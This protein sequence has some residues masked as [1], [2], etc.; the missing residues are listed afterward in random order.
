MRVD[1]ETAADFL[2]RTPESLRCLLSGVRDDWMRAHYGEGTWSPFD[3]VGHLIHG[4]RTDWIPRARIIL[5]HGS[6]RAFEPFDRHAQAE[7]SRGKGMED[8]LGEFGRLRAANVK[9]L[10]GLGLKPGDLERPGLHPELG[11]VTL[12]QLIATWVVHDL[13]HIAQIG[14]AM[15]FQLRGEV[16]VWKEYLGI[17]P[18]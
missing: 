8:L 12:G 7:D 17:L 3:I 16:G 10:R 4:E 5:V 14:K 15:A 2:E 18:R 9:A 13:H 6:A 11:A 1:V